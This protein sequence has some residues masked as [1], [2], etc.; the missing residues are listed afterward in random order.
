M[1]DK[2]RVKKESQGGFI[3][4]FSKNIIYFGSIWSLLW[5]IV[6]QNLVIQIWIALIAPF[7]GIKAWRKAVKYN[8]TLFLENNVNDVWD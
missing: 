2:N 6:V 1:D 7:S 8:K 4:T 5:K 3:D